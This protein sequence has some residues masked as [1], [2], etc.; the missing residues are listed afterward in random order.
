MARR[1]I[2]SL[3]LMAL[4]VAVGSGTLALPA[5]AGTTQQSAGSCTP[6]VLVLSAM[7]L[8]LD[9]L[10]AHAQ[11]DLAHPV[12]LNDRPFVFGTLEGNQVIVGL[13]G[14]GPENAWAATAAA[15]AT[16]RC[17][18]GSSAISDVVFSGTSGGDYIGDVSVPSAWYYYGPSFAVGDLS[19]TT[20]VAV[21]PALLSL[22]PAAAA[23]ATPQLEQSTPPGDPA[24]AC[25]LTDSTETPVTVEHTP[26]VVYSTPGS[27]VTGLSIDDFSGRTLPCVPT[28]NDIFGCT[29][30]RELDADAAA[31]AENL[32]QNG[33]AFAEPGFFEGYAD[34]PTFDTPP[35]TPWQDNE[36]AVV[37]YVSEVLNGTP[38]IGFRAASDG[39]SGD[40]A[41]AYG[42]DPLMLPGFPSQFFV[43]RQLAA[44]NAAAMTLAFLH[45]LAAQ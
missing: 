7:P 36:T 41:D 10:L 8:E 45:Q 31:Q 12:M 2:V 5:A 42:G 30:C 9:P 38:F 3:M 37:A 21:S 22:V 18:D 14:I 40:P 1:R 11:A 34:T 17:P 26:D 32:A 13:T 33:P 16:F 6:R 29:P 4:A 15:F 24:C 43:Y 25:E 44:N 39:P 27:T 19:T 23:V 20:G 35:Y 28:A